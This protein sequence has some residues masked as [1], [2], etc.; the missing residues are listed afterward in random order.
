MIFKQLILI[1][2]CLSVTLISLP[3]S[4]AKITKFLVY[5]SVALKQTKKY[6]DGRPVDLVFHFQGANCEENLISLSFALG[7]LNVSKMK[8]VYRKNLVFVS[9]FDFFV[10]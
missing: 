8:D 10:Y 1:A 6:L 3:P 7:G 9:F 2:V 5:P 4:D